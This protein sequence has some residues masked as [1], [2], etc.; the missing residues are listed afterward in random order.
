MPPSQKTKTSTP[1]LRN[2]RTDLG[3]ARVF[4][5]THG[6]TGLPNVLALKGISPQN[7]KQ[8]EEAISILQH[9]TD[10]TLADVRC[11]TAN[12]S[13][14]DLRL[15]D[16][17]LDNYRSLYS[18]R[19]LFP[20]IRV[21]IFALKVPHKIV[22]MKYPSYRYFGLWRN[23]ALVLAGLIDCID[24]GWTREPFSPIV[25]AESPKGKAR[26]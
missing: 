15:I 18:C 24:D 4:A 5:V 1:Q 12:R 8:L 10:E 16:I 9:F 13:A 20:S 21:P 22:D 26:R 19:T 23:Q 3:I 25:P 7:Q 6:F 11:R 14:L 17:A 2:S